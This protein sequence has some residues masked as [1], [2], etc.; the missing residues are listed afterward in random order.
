MKKNVVLKILNLILLVLFVNQ[1][2]TVLFRE[3]LSLKAFQFFHK[4]GGM[5][6]LGLILVHFIS[7][8]N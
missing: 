2:V 7:N 1:A 4:G 8:F 5:I 6:L 3:Q